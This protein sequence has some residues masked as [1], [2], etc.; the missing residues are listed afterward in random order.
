[1]HVQAYMGIFYM[2][3]F[4]RTVITVMKKTVSSKPKSVSKRT[5]ME[6][7]QPVRVSDMGMGTKAS[8]EVEKKQP[9]AATV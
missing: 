3:Y 7:V 6:H 1:M 9:I 2:F 4:T 8:K 5:E